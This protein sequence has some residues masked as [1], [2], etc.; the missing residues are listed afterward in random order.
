MLPANIEL[1]VE[2]YPRITLTFRGAVRRD[3][4]EWL[5]EGFE[6]LLTRPMRYA[7]IVR[8]VDSVR[9]IGAAERQL[10]ARWQDQ[11]QEAIAEKN[12]CAALVLTSRV[13]R[14]IFRAYSWLVAAPSPQMVF[15]NTAD[16][17]QWVD[18]MLASE[19][20]SAARSA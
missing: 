9:G 10:I 8:D 19:R 15:S 1:D 11:R 2:R 16:A 4:L 6:E 5:I 20:S 3:D 14:G 13:A 17:E 12:L 18:E 7:I